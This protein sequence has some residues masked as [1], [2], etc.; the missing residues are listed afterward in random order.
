[1]FNS[2]INSLVLLY[3]Q[4]WSRDYVSVAYLN[5]LRLS[6]PEAPRHIALDIQEQASQ[7]RC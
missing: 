4:Y 7:H 5:E 3:L 6:L 1:M 2:F